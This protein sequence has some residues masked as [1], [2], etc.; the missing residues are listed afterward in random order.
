MCLQMASQLHD[1]QDGLRE[2]ICSQG[3]MND[4]QRYRSETAVDQT[5]NEHHRVNVLPFHVH[6][7]MTHGLEC[8]T[9]YLIAVQ[10]RDTLSSEYMIFH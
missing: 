6:L 8:M 7:Y 4:V 1:N 9:F 5:H 10:Y 3:D 2:P